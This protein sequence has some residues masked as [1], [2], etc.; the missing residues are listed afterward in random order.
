MK[1]A[2]VAKIFSEYIE[3]G[4]TP[5]GTKVQSFF[6]N[7]PPAHMRIVANN[8]SKAFEVYLKAEE[9][10]AEMRKKRKKEIIELKKK[11]KELG[12]VISEE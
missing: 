12:L 10:K 2:E 6:N 1:P 4:S 5:K 7:L 9:E 8:V 11:A 3:E